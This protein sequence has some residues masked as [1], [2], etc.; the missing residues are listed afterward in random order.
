MLAPDWLPKSEQPIRSQVI[1]LAQFFTMTTSQKFPLQMTKMIDLLEEFMSHRQHSYM[2]LDGSSKIHERRDMV[3]D[4][5]SRQVSQ[6][7]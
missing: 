2:R 5:Q 3:A 7:T 6:A 4:F 1:K